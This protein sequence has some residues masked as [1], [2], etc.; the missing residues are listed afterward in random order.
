[1]TGR[2]PQPTALRRAAGNPGKRAWNHDEPQPPNDLPECPA[3]LEGE[4]QAEWQRLASTLHQMGVLT[5]VDRAAMAAY[6]Q[7]WGRWVEAEQKLKVTPIMLKSP[8]GHVQQSPWLSIVNRQL[9]LMGRFMTELG[10][11]PAA[12]SRIVSLREPEPVHEPVTVV[13]LIVGPEGR[14]NPAL[15]NEVVISGPDARL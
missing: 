11:T 7:C 6:C 9:E 12:R 1:M 10:L 3:H 2:R 14:D 8:S 13:R 15:P 4:A 5:T